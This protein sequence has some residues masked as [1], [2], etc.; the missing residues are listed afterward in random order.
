MF[1]EIFC[2]FFDWFVFFLVAEL[3]E[4]FVYFGDQ[5]LVCC[6]IC[7]YF[8]PFYKLSFLMVKGK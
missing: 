7:K 3:Y 2:P 6:I 8:L 5:A 4:L 1:V